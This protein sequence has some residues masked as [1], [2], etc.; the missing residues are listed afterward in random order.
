MYTLKEIQKHNNKDSLWLIIN[1]NVYDVTEFQKTHP[2]FFI[3]L[4]K[5]GDMIL[6]GGGSRATELFESHHPS[7]LFDEN[8]SLLKKYKIGVCTENCEIYKKNEIYKNLKSLV[9]KHFIENKVFIIL[10]HLKDF[11]Q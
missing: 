10:S 8:N 1:N 4:I 3:S 2:G 9:E 5:G 11:T 6:L 7:Y